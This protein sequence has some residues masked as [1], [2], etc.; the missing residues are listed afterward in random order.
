[1][2]PLFWKFC[3]LFILQILNIWQILVQRF[4]FHPVCFGHFFKFCT[5]A[6]KDCIDQIFAEPFSLLVSNFWR[7]SKFLF[8][9]AN[10]DDNRTIPDTPISLQVHRFPWGCMPHNPGPAPPG[11][12]DTSVLPGRCLSGKCNAPLCQKPDINVLCPHPV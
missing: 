6:I 8:V 3:S 1:M 5:A 7:H 9:Y 12:P 4:I 10:I 11:W 2:T